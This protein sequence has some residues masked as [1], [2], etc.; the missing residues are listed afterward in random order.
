MDASLH[1]LSIA[2]AGR[3]LREGS[4]TS[5]GLTRHALDRIAAIDP[6]VTA[7]ITVSKERALSD[8]ARADADFAR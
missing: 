6:R 7:F 5:T 3:R 1:E 2:E 4:L 8:A